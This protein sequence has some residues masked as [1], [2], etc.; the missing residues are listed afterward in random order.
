MSAPHISPPGIPATNTSLINP[1]YG[2]HRLTSELVA[3]RRPQVIINTMCPGIVK[4]DLSRHF[5][6]KWA[7]FIVITTI[8]TGLFGKTPENGART[9]MAAV[10]TG[11]SEHVSFQSPTF[12]SIYHVLPPPHFAV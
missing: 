10:T 7:I 12:L 11:E 4:T 8:Y 1:T 2:G 6:E 3:H 9:Y 5:T